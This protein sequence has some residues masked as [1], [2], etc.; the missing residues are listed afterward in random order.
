MQ[1]VTLQIPTTRLLAISASLEHLVF[2][3]K[4]RKA[5]DGDNICGSFN[6]IVEN[7][8]LTFEQENRGLGGW[9]ATVADYLEKKHGI[10]LNKLDARKLAALL[11]EA[12]ENDDLTPPGLLHDGAPP[13]EA[14]NLHIGVLICLCAA[15]HDSVVHLAKRE[16][17]DGAMFAEDWGRMDRIA[18]ALRDIVSHLLYAEI[19]SDLG[20]RAAVAGREAAQR[21]DYTEPC[22]K[23]PSPHHLHI[24]PNDLELPTLEYA[25]KV[26]EE[27]GGSTLP[28]GLGSLAELARELLA[29]PT[30][31]DEENPD[32]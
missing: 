32:A 9:L 5:L 13:T 24:R 19:S 31:D 7:L 21:G 8:Q 27:I 20:T 6:L 14:V 26:F 22:K 18:N 2:S 10:R 17:Q 28:A 1:Y 3:K 16:E 4:F 11:T 15:A 29:Q 25:E 12:D 23:H 30:N